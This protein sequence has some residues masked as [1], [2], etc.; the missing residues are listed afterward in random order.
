MGT[1]WCQFCGV[2][3]YTCLGSACL[4]LKPAIKRES[5]IDRSNRNRNIP[6][7]NFKDAKALGCVAACVPRGRKGA[8]SSTYLKVKKLGYTNSVGENG[9]RKLKIP[10]HPILRKAVKL[11]VIYIKY[12]LRTF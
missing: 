10:R 9:N 8:F 6:G 4:G 5:I 11:K 7:L 1:S 2:G 3:E 12:S